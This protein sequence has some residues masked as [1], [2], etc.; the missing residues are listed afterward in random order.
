[1]RK[2]LFILLLSNIIL[3]QQQGFSQSL[4]SILNDE[5]LNF[6]EK[7]E[8]IEN[9]SNNLKVGVEDYILKRYIRWRAFWD[10]RVGLNGDQKAYAS[11]WH[12]IFN[13]ASIPTGGSG[14]TW[15]FVGP[16]ENIMN[17]PNY[18]GYVGALAVDP[19]NQNII[20]AGS[21]TGGLWKST[22]STATY[23]HWECLTNDYAGMGVSDILVHPNNS[24]IIFIVTGIHFNGL[25]KMTGDYSLG[26]YKSMDGGVTWNLMTDVGFSTDEN[27][28]L[29]KIIMDPGNPNTIYILS[30]T[31]VYKSIDGG[32]SWDN[33]LVNANENYLRFRSI[34]INPINTSEIYISGNNAI[35][36]T[37]NAG[38]TWSKITTLGHSENSNVSVSW[39]PIE[40]CIYALYENNKI[41]Y[42]KKSFD[43][44]TTWIS[45]N[46]ISSVR[47]YVNS[48][49]I[50]PNGNIYA[51]GISIRRSTNQGSDFTYQTSMHA[52][53]RDFLFPNNINDNIAYIA[54]DGG[55]VRNTTGN[56]N[57]WISCNGDLSVNQ[58]YDIAISEQDP[59]LILGG[60]HDCGTLRRKPDGNWEHAAYGDGGTS[61]INQSSNNIQFA[62]MGQLLYRS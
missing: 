28:Y 14:T 19:N 34:A 11:V 48:L 56:D 39:N 22:N 6:Y 1:M 36:K 10:T 13:S 17:I 12:S 58:F 4:E 23:P 32:N 52:D 7:I 25:I 2:I 62:Q 50:S 55:I 21:A 43:G 46:T 35:Y 53:I 5:R 9:D 41:G 16:N 26:A 24:S 54:T 3:L 27:I 29:S 33:T 40:N 47:N 31:T 45:V 57:D 61:A 30:T 38:S 42:L 37:S 20:Y 8:Q 49:A 59:N 51:G 15:E 18:M 60:S 44:G